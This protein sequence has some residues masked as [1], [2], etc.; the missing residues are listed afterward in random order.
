M[1]MKEARIICAA[2]ALCLLFSLTAC[3]ENS[4]VPAVTTSAAPAP[5]TTAASST[6]EDSGSDFEVTVTPL[7]GTE[8]DTADCIPAD[9]KPGD[10]VT[11]EITW[12]EG[13]VAY[14]QQGMSSGIMYNKLQFY[15]LDINDIYVLYAAPN[16]SGT[17]GSLSLLA[18][19]VDS[20]AESYREDMTEEELDKI[21]PWQISQI[22]GRAEPI[23]Q[24]LK[25]VFAE[26]YG[27]GFESGC[28]PELYLVDSE[29]K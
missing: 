28:Q 20:F 23:P 10:T 3:G 22:N 2:A 11:G 24:E 6:A 21:K 13:P 12:C 14:F 4:T 15:A 17:A 5:E 25:D 19:Q 9:L 1:N 29:V 18:S 7:T 16:N 8:Y 27:A 26:W